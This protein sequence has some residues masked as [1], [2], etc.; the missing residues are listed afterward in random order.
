MTLWS[1]T[2]LT[3]SAQSGLGIAGYVGRRWV[4][5]HSRLCTC[6]C[7]G[8]S[9]SIRSDIVERAWEAD[10]AYRGTVRRERRETGSLRLGASF[11]LYYRAF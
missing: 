7:M 6:V 4:I 5:P 1:Y 8:M 3:D 10:I 11:V 2:M 9:L